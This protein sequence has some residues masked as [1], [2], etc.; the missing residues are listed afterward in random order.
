MTPLPGGVGL[1]EASQA[2]TMQA[3]GYSSALGISLSLLIRARDLVVGIFGLWV[4]GLIGARQAPA[5]EKPAMLAPAIKLSE[6]DAIRP[7][8]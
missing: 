6:V 2:L 5:M 4:G 7:A 8:D 3:F 1:L